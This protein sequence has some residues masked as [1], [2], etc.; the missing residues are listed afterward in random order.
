VRE[1]E[2][3]RERER[4]GRQ[5]TDVERAAGC[6]DYAAIGGGTSRALWR[7]D[8]ADA[9]Q[10]AGHGEVSRER[11]GEREDGHRRC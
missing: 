5:R 9:L 2:R 8:V 10:N 4:R 6:V 7:V 1:K 3:E 11:A